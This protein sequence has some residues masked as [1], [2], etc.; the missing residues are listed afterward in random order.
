M[1][2]PTPFTV[3]N[4]IDNF[5]RSTDVA[6]ALSALDIFTP[7]SRRISI[8]GQLTDSDWMLEVDASGND[9][10]V[11]LPK[12]STHTGKVLFIRVV[13]TDG[14]SNTVTLM[15]HVDDSFI[16]LSGTP[17]SSTLSSKTWIM[18]AGSTN[19]WTLVG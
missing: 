3:A 13:G 14:G 5:M 2:T 8:D 7:S 4:H 17:I 19:W 15:K 18:G 11:T 12:A 9:V 16:N 6:N 10:T 1:P